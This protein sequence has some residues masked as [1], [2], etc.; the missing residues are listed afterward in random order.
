MNPA[1]YLQIVARLE[2][3]EKFVADLKAQQEKPPEPA[4]RGPGRPPKAP[5]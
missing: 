2:R 3:L 5:Q 1:V 4:K